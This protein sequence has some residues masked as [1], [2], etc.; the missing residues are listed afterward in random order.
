MN[1]WKIPAALERMAIERDRSCVYC[2]TSFEAAAAS[3]SSRPSWEHIV[4]DASIVTAENIALCC[5]A[6]NASKRSK[7]LTS[8]L[9]TKY[10]VSRGIT[11]RNVAVVIQA[12][13]AQLGPAKGRPRASGPR[14]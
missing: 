4:N 5:I 12:A 8:W 13:L 1:R 10:C 7:D 6:C 9:Q 14:S 11:E 2:G 3:R